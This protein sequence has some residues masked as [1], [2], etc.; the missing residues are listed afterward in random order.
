[1]KQT[2]VRPLEPRTRGRSA[3]LHD[4]YPAGSE[5]RSET[6]RTYLRVSERIECE[7][8]A[9]TKFWISSRL[10]LASEFKVEGRSAGEVGS[11]KEQQRETNFE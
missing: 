5:T 6:R 10:T 4:E 7:S 11:S 2:A 1:M 3:S 8:E 9:R